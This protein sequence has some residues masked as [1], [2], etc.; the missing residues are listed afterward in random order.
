VSRP[1]KR[2]RLSLSNDLDDIARSE[3]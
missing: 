1:A 3:P 2:V